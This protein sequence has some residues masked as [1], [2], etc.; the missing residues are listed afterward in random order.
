MHAE[1]SDRRIERELRDVEARYRE[2]VE[3]LPVV[4]YIETD[5]PEPRTIYVSRRAEELSGYST[6]EW[7]TDQ[8]LWL[9]FIHPEDLGKVRKAWELALR[10]KEPFFAE[11]RAIHKD[12]HVFWVH[13]SSRLVRSE[14][15]APLFWEGIA[16]DI[17]EAKRAEEELRGS[18][19]RY[20]ILVEQVPVLVYIDSNDPHPESLYV[21][22]MVQEMLGHTPEE[23][24]ANR[25]FWQ[26]TM[27]PDDW[28][29]VQAAWERSVRT[30]EPFHDEYRHLRPDGTVVWVSD[31][32]RP[33]LGARGAPRFWQGVIQDITERRRAEDEIR[34]SEARYRALVEQVPAVVFI[35]TNEEAPRCLYVSPQARDVLG[36]RPEEY[37]DDPALWMRTIHP[38]D[39]E[40]VGE[41]WVTSV[42]TQRPFVDDFRV[43]R[44]DGSVAWLHEEAVPILDREGSPLWQGL[45]SDVT[46]HKRVEL[47]LRASE[48][49]YRALVEQVPAVVY[50]MGPDDERRTLYVSQHVESIFGYTRKEWLD[51][52]DIW[53]ELLH[54]DDREVVLAAHDLHNQTGEP[55]SEEYRLIASDGRVVWV[56]DQA[57]LARDEQGL[58]PTWHGVM[59][60]VTGRKELEGQLLLAND[61]LEARVQTRT[62][63]LAEANE[64]MALEIGERK[65]AEAEARET[66]ERFRRLIEDLPAVVYLWHVND[67]GDE[68]SLS[69]TSPQIEQMLGYTPDEWNSPVLWKERIHPHDRERVLEAFTRVEG[70]GEPYDYEYRYLAKDGHVVW[71]HSHA[72]LLQRDRDGRPLLYQ[73]V[74]VDITERKEA[75]LKAE[76]AERRLQAAEALASVGLYDIELVWE[77]D[78]RRL[79]LRYFTPSL[80]RLIGAT[81]QDLMHDP[82]NWARSI[83]PD[84]AD[85]V[86]EDAERQ[87]RTGRPTERTYRVLDPSGKVVWVRSESRCVGRDGEGRPSRFQGAIIDVTKEM[88]E[89]EQLRASSAALRSFVDS[90]PGI[91]WMQVVANGPGSGRTVYVGPQVERILGYTE[92][93][94]L[95]EPD[96]FS[97]MI[98]PADRA[99]IQEHSRRH[100]RTGEPWSEEYR[101]IARDGRVVWFRSEG[102]ASR[103]EDGTLVWHG[104]AF[105]VT[106]LREHATI[107][108]PDVTAV[109]P[110]G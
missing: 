41:L 54:P 10:T 56:H 53:V 105:D 107:R 34:T 80:A 57:L 51:Q 94:L 59:L 83:H 8:E 96:H 30:G 33:V 98:H 21:S 74:L 93:E 7:T 58:P 65:R 35:D 63:E 68:T 106:S 25:D 49:R 29:R 104:I 103:T 109:E 91:P 38:D 99:R 66:R 67:P 5:E 15:G 108:L 27:H 85:G 26:Q 3:R 22:P 16:R 71:V 110:E 88:A 101:M 52:P 12:G 50:E 13:D 97:R 60:D 61:E 69:Y 55:W 17:T 42:R 20:R 78:R 44:P 24:Y 79:E 73:G 40:R 90:I 32:S 43:V 39:R 75:E 102:I 86:I 89:Q 76:E 4:V 82:G 1:P 36:R 19:A 37:V 47:E 84:D 23:Y 2:L 77:G 9:R 70:T 92:E 87:F 6:D 72:T 45:I 28:P 95:G 11:Y 18:E 62:A 46:H 64:M 100:D 14:D 31:D 81:T 48:E